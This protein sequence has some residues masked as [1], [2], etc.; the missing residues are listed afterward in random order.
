[1]SGYL[2]GCAGKITSYASWSQAERVARRLRRDKHNNAAPYR[3]HFCSGIHVGTGAFDTDRASKRRRARRL[4]L[5][6]A[7]W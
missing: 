7:D 3:C 2:A 1:M 5:M 6:E 4:E